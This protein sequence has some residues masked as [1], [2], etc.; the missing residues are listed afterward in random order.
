ML[1]NQTTSSFNPSSEVAMAGATT[2]HPHFA[3]AKAA[4]RISAPRGF[5]LDLSDS[6]SLAG[7]LMAAVLAAMLVVADQ[8]VD[9]WSDGHLLAVWVGLWTIIFAVMALSAQSLR[10]LA[11]KVAA[12]W[13]RRS[14]A[15]AA[16]RSDAAMLNLARQDHRVMRDLQVAAMHSEY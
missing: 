16:R 10:Q 15:R 3:P 13:T 11:G 9:P 12:V 4:A 14:Q 6:H 5:A 7:I 2:I 8:L 1:F